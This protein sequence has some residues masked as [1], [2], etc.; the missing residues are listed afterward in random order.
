VV[1]EAAHL[2]WLRS[3]MD[4]RCGLSSG[5]PALQAQSPEFKPQSHEKKRERENQTMMFPTRAN[6]KQCFPQNHTTAAN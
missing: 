6:R 4:D 3:K 1:E 2:I 5:V